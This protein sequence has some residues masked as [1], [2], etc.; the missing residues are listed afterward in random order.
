MMKKRAERGGGVAFG[1]PL[2]SNGVFAALRPHATVTVT[3]STRLPPGHRAALIATLP[4]H[5]GLT[6]FHYAGEHRRVEAVSAARAAA[7]DALMENPDATYDPDVDWWRAPPRRSVA[8]GA[9]RQGAPQTRSLRRT[10]HG[11]TRNAKT[12]A[13]ERALVDALRVHVAASHNLVRL[14]FEGTKLGPDAL[15][16]LA[17]GITDNRGSLERLSLAATGLTDDGMLNWVAPALARSPSI[18]VV[19]L[20]ANALGEAGAKRLGLLLHAQS[21]ARHAQVW[22]TSLRDEPGLPSSHAPGILRLTLA[23]NRVTGVGAAALAAGLRDDQWFE[24]LDLR[25]N[26]VTQIGVDA[27]N[28]VVPSTCLADLALDGNAPD[29]DCHT[30]DALAATLV[31]NAT[32][33]EARLQ[34][35]LAGPPASSRPH[36]DA[37]PT[38]QRDPV[39]EALFYE[40]SPAPA[41][42]PPTSPRRAARPRSSAAAR[43]RAT[44]ARAERK[45]V[46]ALV[47]SLHQRLDDQDRERAAERAQLEQTQLLVRSLAATGGLPRHRPSGQSSASSP[48]L[49]SIRSSL[50]SADASLLANREQMMD[51]L[52][53]TVEGFHTFLDNLGAAL[54]EEA[55]DAPR[56]Y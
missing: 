22:E 13:F 41:R 8:D 43:A 19:D 56:G 9:A 39:V 24:H 45:R 6:A 29:L 55:S 35:A 33:A 4:K 21:Q 30:V 10:R 20:S 54:T 3:G 51:L 37:S 17:A 15:A 1:P 14:S 42:S 53:S 28:L 27:F 50:A 25:Y 44:E 40:S 23:F 34:R 46:K 16:K 48:Y 26:R 18:R 49:H 52:E 36:F 32:R 11:A 47:T 38:R 5:H 31:D 2:P 7:Y 12:T